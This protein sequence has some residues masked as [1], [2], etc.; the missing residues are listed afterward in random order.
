MDEILSGIVI[1]NPNFSVAQLADQLGVQEYIVYE[2]CNPN[3]QRRF[4]LALVIPLTLFTGDTAL[5]EHIAAR[6]GLVAFEVRKRGKTPIENAED[7]LEFLKT[8]IGVLGGMVE[9]FKAHGRIDRR[10]TLKDID[11]FMRTMAGL[12]NDIENMS[13]QMVLDLEK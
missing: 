9:T 12:Y 8:F 5:I 6:A 2:W 4:P 13:D 7:L 3:N 11:K 1:R 10:G